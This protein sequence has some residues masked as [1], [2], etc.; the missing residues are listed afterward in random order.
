MKV[1]SRDC[2]MSHIIKKYL[3]LDEKCITVK[4][5]F[6]YLL[7][8]GLEFCVCFQ[9]ETPV[10]E[11]C[12]PMEMVCEFLCVCIFWYIKNVYSCILHV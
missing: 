4:K 2:D 8:T 6:C 3:V 11:Q 9:L 12:V 5:I 10:S 1:Y 7:H